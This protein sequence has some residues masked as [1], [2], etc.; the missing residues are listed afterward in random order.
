MAIFLPHPQGGIA[1]LEENF[2]ASIAP[3]AIAAFVARFGVVAL[4]GYGLASRFELLIYSWSWPLAWV[5]DL[6]GICAG[7]GLVAVRTA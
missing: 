1:F 6:V 2:L 5:P 4:A 7:A 3:I